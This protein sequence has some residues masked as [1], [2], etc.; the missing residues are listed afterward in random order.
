MDV[1]VDGLIADCA[2][3][4]RDHVDAYAIGVDLF[5]RGRHLLGHHR[6]AGQPGLVHGRDQRP[7][8][9]DV[10]LG[11]PG[12]VRDAGALREL[13]LRLGA[14]QG[15]DRNLAGRQVQYRLLAGS[16]HGVSIPFFLG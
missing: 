4:R 5:D 14:E 9:V 8:A 13:R 6:Q 2:A 3:V 12:R 16:G 15:G 1:E 7:P 10:V 11:R